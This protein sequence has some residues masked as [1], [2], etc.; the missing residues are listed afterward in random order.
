MRTEETELAG[1][2]EAGPKVTTKLSTHQPFSTG[3][4]GL[5]P[6]GLTQPWAGAAFK[7][8]AEYRDQK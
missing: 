3:E 8:F 7:D 1:F 5:G 2:P 4:I 6:Q